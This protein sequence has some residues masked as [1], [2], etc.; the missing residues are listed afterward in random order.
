M[1]PDPLLLFVVVTENMAAA[2]KMSDGIFCHDVLQTDTQA[3]TGPRQEG[4]NLE[5]KNNNNGPHT[6]NDNKTNRDWID[7]VRID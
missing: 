5:D 2:V 3:L 4:R 1:L 7:M 6:K